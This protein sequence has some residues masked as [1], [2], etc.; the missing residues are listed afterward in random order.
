MEDGEKRKKGEGGQKRRTKTKNST[1][2]SF[3]KRWENEGKNVA[4]WC[5]DDAT[6]R[7]LRKEQRVRKKLTSPAIVDCDHDQDK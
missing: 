1:S 7:S 2:K 3:A 6:G 4:C 5:F